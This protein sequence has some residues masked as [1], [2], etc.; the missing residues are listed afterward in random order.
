MS[1]TYNYCHGFTEKI[2]WRTWEP[3]TSGGKSWTA[4]ARG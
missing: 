2:I 4:V 3:S 1:C